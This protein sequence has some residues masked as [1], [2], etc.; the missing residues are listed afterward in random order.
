ML[1]LTSHVV[2]GRSGKHGRPCGVQMVADIANDRVG[3][4]LETAQPATGTFARTIQFV[5]TCPR[6]WIILR[7][8]E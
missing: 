1:S 8:L 3:F 7:F 2:K 6:T 5:H 4:D